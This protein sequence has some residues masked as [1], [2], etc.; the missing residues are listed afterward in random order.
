MA[1][2]NDAHAKLDRAQAHFKTLDKEVLDFLGRDPYPVRG[3]ANEEKTR[4]SLRVDIR[5][6]VPHPDL[7]LI[8]GDCVHNARSALDHLAWQM[9]GADPADTRT[10]FP[11]FDDPG[12]FARFSGAMIAR[13]TD[14]R[15]VAFVKWLQPYRRKKE[16]QIDLLWLLQALDV[17]DKHKLLVPVAAVNADMTVT[18]TVPP[19]TE[20]HLREEL[21]P[22]PFV[23]GAE[24]GVL[25]I[26]DGPYDTFTGK[27]TDAEV[28]VK[29]NH[30]FDITLSDQAIEGA[31]PYRA[32]IDA[33]AC[34]RSILETAERCRLV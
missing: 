7:S 21:I 24:I 4:Y 33:I 16:G 19:M 9:A 32:L 25:V 26:T 17:A 31:A 11:I 34:V 12:K 8:A 3:E 10:Q 20:V 6:E 27:K 18:W 14:R 5:E 30:I 22:G 29:T 1:P 2:L 15:S 28:Q 23:D 13:L